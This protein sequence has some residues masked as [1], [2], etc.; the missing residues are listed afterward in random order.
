MTFREFKLHLLNLQAWRFHFARELIIRQSSD[1]NFGLATMNNTE[2][3]LNV[4]VPT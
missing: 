3:I 1:L 4:K 2:M